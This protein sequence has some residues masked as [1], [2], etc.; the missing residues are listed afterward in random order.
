MS[1]AEYPDAAEWSNFMET[2]NDQMVDAMRVTTDSQAALVDSWADLYEDLAS[3]D[4]ASDADLAGYAAANRVWLDAFEEQF[5]EYIDV[6]ARDGTFSA[7]AA[8][9][10]WLEA[11]NEAFKELMRTPGFTAGMN[12]TMEAALDRQLE[13]REASETQLRQFGFATR[14]DVEEVGQ[15]LLEIERR[16]QELEGRLEEE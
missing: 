9:D 16:L 7:E 1:D 12:R 15:R 13:A 3:L 6:M 10:R 5:D 14:S 2:V 4:A 11:A 8:R